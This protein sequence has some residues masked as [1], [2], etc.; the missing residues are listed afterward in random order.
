MHRAGPLQRGGTPTPYDRWLATLYGAGAT[1]LAM[2]GKCGMMVNL[3]GREIG[4]VSLAEAVEQTPK[5]VNP[6][7]DLITAARGLGIVFGDE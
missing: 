3:Q 2:S 6:D 4:A 7:G 1:R 5:L